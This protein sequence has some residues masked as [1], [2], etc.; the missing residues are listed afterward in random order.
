[1][2]V[3]CGVF[4]FVCKNQSVGVLCTHLCRHI[5]IIALKLTVK[6]CAID[7][8]PGF[9]WSICSRFPIMCQWCAWP[10]FIL[11]E[12]CSWLPRWTQVH[13]LFKQCGCWTAK[14][15]LYQSQ[16]NKDSCFTISR[17]NLWPK[18]VAFGHS[19]QAAF[20]Q[21]TPQLL[22]LIK[23]R[24]AFARLQFPVGLRFTCSEA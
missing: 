14:L 17:F 18:K 2:F 22:E 10:H 12:I 5:L 3:H 6:S 1:M 7:T 21:G 15:Q 16:T 23:T 11:R 20:P 13:L 9:C 8:R 4:Q 24:V 19:L